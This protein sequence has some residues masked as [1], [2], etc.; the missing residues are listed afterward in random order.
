[1]SKPNSKS[2]RAQQH[3]PAAA[4]S[5]AA[6]FVIALSLIYLAIYAAG[7]ILPDSMWGVNFLKYLDLTQHVLAIILGVAVSA[8]V[9]IAAETVDLPQLLKRLFIYLIAPAVLLGLFHYFAVANHF[10]GDGILRARELETGFVILP[11]EPLAYLVN[12][13]AYHLLGPAFGFS[14]SESIAMVSY[15]SGVLYY[16]ALLPLI[17]QLTR[18]RAQRVFYFL[19]LYFSGTTLLF[20]GYSET[21]MLLP[22]LVALYIYTGI[23]SI[24]GELTPLVP[25]GLLLLLV[26]FHFKSLLFAPSVFVLAWF[27]HKKGNRLAWP[28]V[29]AVML[30][31][32]AAIALVPAI[33]KLPRVPITEFVFGLSEKGA[34]YPFF[35][36]QHFADIYSELM[37]TGGVAVV[38]LLSLSTYSYFRK[39]FRKPEVLYVAGSAP[40]AVAMIIFLYSELGFALDWDLFSVVGLILN[41]VAVAALAYSDDMQ[42]GRIARVAVVSVGITSFLAYAMVNDDFDTTIERNVDLLELYGGNQAAI[43]FESMGNY[44]NLAGHPDIAEKLWKRSVRIRPHVRMFSNLGQLALNRGNLNEAEYYNIK[45]L[46]LDSTLYVLQTNLGMTYVRM[47]DFAK[48]EPYLRRAIELAPDNSSVYHNYAVAL[49]SQ[50]R[51]QEAE[52]QERIALGMD[53]NSVMYLVGMGAALLGLEKP[54]D[55]RQYLLRALQRDPGNPQAASNFAN[56]LTAL[57]QHHEA[58]QFLETYLR[59]YPGSPYASVFERKAAEVRDYLNSQQQPDSSEPGN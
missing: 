49:M 14:A 36:M 4:S 35:S 39:A 9:M 52:Y 42:L 19:L 13:G 28:A 57:G 53:P 6:F 20:C 15:A 31:S 45:G 25:V 41:F 44:L 11:T 26:L 27:L 22:A 58:L 18:K 33:A 29:G 30:L 59:T 10:L 7:E 51:Y 34:N 2:N 48:G 16:Y 38:L 55:A 5:S 12:Y 43:G 8:I 24:R 3:E 50:Q 23:K 40:L 56:T 47:G 21:Y 1:M 17:F 54:L 32:I 46:E 37:L